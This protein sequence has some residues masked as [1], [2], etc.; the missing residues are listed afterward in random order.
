VLESFKTILESEGFSCDT[1]TT[2]LDALE[3]CRAHRYDLAL[4]GIEGTVLSVEMHRRTPRMIKIILASHASLEKA[5]ESVN[6]GADA[7]LTKP[8]NPEG[9]LRVV[10]EKGRWAKKKALK[11]FL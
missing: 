4:L 1:V 3:K 9:L 5:V 6:F 7:Y 8:V 2:S 10:E 11:R